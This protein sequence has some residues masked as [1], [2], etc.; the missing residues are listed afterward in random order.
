M[1]HILLKKPFKYSMLAC[2]L[3]ANACAVQVS[4]S[5]LGKAD[6]P[7]SIKID[8]VLYNQQ[9]YLPESSKEVFVKATQKVRYQLFD[10]NNNK[11]AFGY[12]TSAEIWP[13]AKQPFVKIDLSQVKKAGIYQLEINPETDSVSVQINIQP[14]I[15]KKPL[16]LA[17]K[18]FYLNRASTELTEEYAAEF[19][20]AAGHPDDV[21]YIHSSAASEARPEGTIVSAPKGWYDAGDYN[22]YAV[23]GSVALYT[24][25]MAYQDFPSIHQLELNIPESANAQPD[26][27]DEIIWQLDW[28]INMQDPND[29]GVYHKLTTKNFS[30]KQMPD[31]ANEPRFMVAKSVSGTLDFA[32]TMAF[33]AHVLKQSMPEQ[34]KVYQQAAINAW[35]WAEQNPD[36]I[37]HQPEDIKTGAYSTSQQNL[38]DEWFWASAELALLTGNAKYWQKAEQTQTDMA[39]PSWS[40]VAPFA[41]IRLAKQTQQTD[42]QNK[43]AQKLK[44]AADRLTQTV[45]TSAIAVPMGSYQNDFVWGSNGVASN[46]ILVLSSAYQLDPKADYKYAMQAGLDYLLGKNPTGYSFVTGVGVKT[47]MHIHHRISEADDVVKPVPGLLAGGPHSGQQDKCEGYPSTEPGLSYV[48]HWCSYATNEIAINWNAP[49][50]YALAAFN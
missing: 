2:A 6:K 46:Q 21:V 23:N 28:L 4:D 5:V 14:N 43:A 20:R 25:L 39:I 16:E 11:V 9:G 36:A 45:K 29:G 15:Y 18:S 37:Y 24:M 30:G 27:L 41:W 22:K 34:A 32:A 10:A 44:T 47:P 35:H 13:H 26:L 17:I 40:Y 38:N 1:T 31:Q 49:F 8:T 3:L 12:S 19:A 48:D 42:W 7:D 50:V 33:A